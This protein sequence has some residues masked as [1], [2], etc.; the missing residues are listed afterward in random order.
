MEDCYE[1]RGLPEAF[2][3]SEGFER[4]FAAYTIFLIFLDGL[5]RGVKPPLPS[6]SM[7]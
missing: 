3:L 2:G 7:P 5:M 4:G 6:E 1:T